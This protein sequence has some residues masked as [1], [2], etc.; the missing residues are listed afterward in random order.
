MKIF[1]NGQQRGE[2]EK[3]KPP[4]S[5]FPDATLGAWSPLTDRY[6]CNGPYP[7]MEVE[8]VNIAEIVA[9]KKA[10]TSEQ[11]KLWEDALKDKYGLPSF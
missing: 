7:D 4:L 9:F 6:I 10:L 5:E 2:T 11:R 3:G 8:P 1:L